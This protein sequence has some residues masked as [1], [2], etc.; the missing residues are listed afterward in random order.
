MAMA[1]S[2]GR[3]LRT[4]GRSTPE[5]RIHSLARKRARTGASYRHSFSTL[6]RQRLVTVTLVLPVLPAASSASARSVWLPDAIGRV[7]HL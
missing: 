2:P 4:T 6:P 5:T 3:A 1:G 7:D